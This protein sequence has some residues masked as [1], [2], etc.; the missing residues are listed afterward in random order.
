MTGYLDLLLRDAALEALIGADADLTAMLSVELALA[1][2]CCTCGLIDRQAADRITAVGHDFRPD[3]AALGEAT[4]KDG[5][6]VPELVRQL[7]AH[8]G[9]PH[10]ACVHFG[11]TSQDIIDTALAVKLVA[12]F[13]LFDRRLGALLGSFDRLTA[14]YGGNALMGRTR[15][16][17]AVP[18]RVADRLAVWRGLVERAHLALGEVRS[19]NLVVTLAGPAGAA[20]AFG[21]RIGEVRHAMAALLHLAVPDHVPHAARDRIA[22]L[23]HWLSQVTGALGKIGQDVALMVQNEI[24][25]I[26]LSGGGGSSAMA[27][28]NNP[29]RAELLVTLAR[30]NAVQISGLHQALVHEQERSGAAWTLEWMILPGML[31][32]SGTALLHADALLGSVRRIGSAG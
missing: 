19:R 32:A 3:R 28:K 24:A 2:A 12:V 1:T 23:G 18:I 22:L 4:L 8:V 5:V 10:D 31:N 7:K 9:A 30:Y 21:D 17:A 20:G 15:M 6:V 26:E 13:E 25:E 16:Q 29:V 11:A 14:T 27:H